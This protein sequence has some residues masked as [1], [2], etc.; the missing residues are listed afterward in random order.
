[1]VDFCL[2]VGSLTIDLA[3]DKLGVVLVGTTRVCV[4]CCLVLVFVIQQDH[5]LADG[6]LVLQAHVAEVPVL[7]GVHGALLHLWVFVDV[8][9]IL[10]PG[11]GAPVLHSFLLLSWLSCKRGRKEVSC[12]LMAATVS[13]QIDE[14]LLLLTLGLRR[15][16]LDLFAFGYLFLLLLLGFAIQ[17][18]SSFTHFDFFSFVLNLLCLVTALRMVISKERH[19]QLQTILNIKF[20]A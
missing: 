16:H 17:G 5:G 15:F 7:V 3:L 14:L 9:L 10:V 2:R 6:R 13:T 11:R 8:R 19:Q 4:H 20:S 1:M 12:R 18:R